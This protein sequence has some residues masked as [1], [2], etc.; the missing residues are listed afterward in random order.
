[1]DLSFPRFDREAELTV[2]P[3]DLAVLIVGIA[4]RQAASPTAAVQAG[5]SRG[6]IDPKL[7]AP[8]HGAFNGPMADALTRWKQE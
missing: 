7:F 2:L 1:M 3:G 6:T 4:A 8:V 5:F